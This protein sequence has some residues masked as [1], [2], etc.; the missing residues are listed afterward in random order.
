MKILYVTTLW[1]TAAIMCLLLSGCL[2]RQANIDNHEDH[3][4]SYDQ[5]EV[6]SAEQAYR[7]S[8]LVNGQYSAQT[9]QAGTDQKDA[10]HKLVT[11]QRGYDEYRSASGQS[12]KSPQ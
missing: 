9:V 5:T 10:Q 1:M 6:E 2:F 8:V 11:D 3:L 7:A 4:L 12:T